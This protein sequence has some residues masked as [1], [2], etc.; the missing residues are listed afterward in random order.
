MRSRNRLGC[1]CHLA[2]KDRFLEPSLL[3]L[4]R[5]KSRHGY[6]LL[7]ELPKFG[8]HRK[9]A[10]PA[11]V[12]RTLRHM[13]DYGMVKSEWDTSGTGP[14]K[15]LYTITKTGKDYL[16][17]WVEVLRGRRDALNA[18]IKEYQQTLSKD[19]HKKKEKT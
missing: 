1:G 11:A 5:E 16:R 17:T 3:Q 19:N 7:N 8:F 13:E 15:R 12:Y 18:F 14:A 6:E 4:L 2:R 9:A 10:D